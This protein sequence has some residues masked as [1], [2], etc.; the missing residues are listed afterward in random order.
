MAVWSGHGEDKCLVFTFLCTIKNQALLK[1]PP[2]LTSRQGFM[3]GDYVQLMNIFT[4]AWPWEICKLNGYGNYVNRFLFFYEILPLFNW[5][6][7]RNITHFFNNLIILHT[8]ADFLDY[9][10][11]NRIFR[12]IWKFI[13][14]KQLIRFFLN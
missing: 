6:L 13:S 10:S 2:P 7:F 12:F 9:V 11:S 14:L 3:S 5:K 4:F 1:V 8:K